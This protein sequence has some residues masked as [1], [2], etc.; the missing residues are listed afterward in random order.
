M[1]RYRTGDLAAFMT[2]PC[3]CGS[4]LRRMGRVQGRR[5]G[6]VRLDASLSLNLAQ[7]D[8]AVFAIPHVVNYTAEVVPNATPTLRLQVYGGGDPAA[9]SLTRVRQA[10]LAVPEV[11]RAMTLGGLVV[12][13]VQLSR[14]DWPTTG[15]LKRKIIQSGKRSI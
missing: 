1:I 5:N 13:P 14:N 11:A 3:P 2:R 15:V 6:G 7:L 4:I 8:E 12:D 9:V 10:V